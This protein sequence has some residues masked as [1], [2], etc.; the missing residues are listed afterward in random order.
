M[1]DYSVVRFFELPFDEGAVRDWA[2]AERHKLGGP[3]TFA[4]L[5]CSPEC[6]HVAAEI[7]EVARIYAHAP[8]IFGCSAV[9]RIATSGEIEE[10]AG[11]TLALAHLPGTRAHPRHIPSDCLSP[12]AS[13]RSIRKVLGQAAN[14]ANAWILF[15]SAES[16]GHEAW[17]TNWDEA[18][19][20]R[21]TIG[22]F[23]S[24]MAH[25]HHAR[26]FLDGKIHTD[27]AIALGLEG[28][29]TIEPVVTQGCRPIGSPW[30]VT[31]ADRNIIHKIGNRPILDVLRD[32]LEGMSYQEQKQAHGNVFIGLVLD[33]Y[34]PSFSTGDFL[35][36]N[37]TA[38]DPRTG[39]VAI[40]TPPRVGQNLQFQIRDP[41]TASFDFEMLLRRKVRELGE[42]TIYGACLC[43]CIG[44][45]TSLYGVP[46]HDV[47]T[48]HK[49]L[50]GLP[51]V[52]LFCNGEFGPAKHS[53]RLHGYAAS[54]GLFV[55]R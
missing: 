51:I 18:T 43:D 35:V 5:F 24:G 17:L 3:V 28:D 37:L 2:T 50:P 27:G 45:G 39:A 11:F 7:M 19:G 21:T 55:G 22:G 10:S 14:D 32:T 31:Q 47:N 6:V 46:D 41:Y 20:G 53:T 34:K 42:R 54:L 49:I 40:A 30:I 4:C 25:G 13:A 29:T 33:E 38:I 9:G 52:G 36:R 12:G 44:R 1:N 15:A 8:I 48:I 26:L 23:A 16:I